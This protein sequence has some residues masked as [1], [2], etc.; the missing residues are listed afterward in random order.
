MAFIL[1]SN[2]LRAAA[3]DGTR[4]RVNSKARRPGALSARAA[5]VSNSASV[6]IEAPRQFTY[7]TYTDLEQIA[8]W[9]PWVH[10]VEYNE[11]DGVSNWALTARGITIGWKARHLEVR[12]GE[13]MTWVS[14]TGLP[15]H[16]EV[17]FEDGP[18]GGSVVTLTIKFEVPEWASSAFS[19]SYVSNFVQKTMEEDL[20]RFRSVA[21]RAQR[22]ARI[23][24]GSPR[25]EL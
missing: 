11:A 16:G 13:K 23:R 9:S 15:N 1:H 5:L 14:E 19:N 17:R 20:N 25:Q 10:S 2:T 4:A 7:D 22:Q 12:P 18:S 6:H 21:L 8:Q 24:A 3:V